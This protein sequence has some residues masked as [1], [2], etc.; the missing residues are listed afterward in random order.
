[1]MFVLQMMLSA[2]TVD[3][4]MFCCCTTSCPI[5]TTVFTGS[6]AGIQIASRSSTPYCRMLVDQMMLPARARSRP[7]AQMML[8]PPAASRDVDQ[9]MLL[10]VDQMILVD[11]MI[12]VDQMILLARVDQMML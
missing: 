8:L 4:M 10:A 6:A 9:M 12:F 7:V 3:Q 2:A 11:Q 1:M 5:P